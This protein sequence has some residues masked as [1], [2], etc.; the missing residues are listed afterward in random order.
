MTDT[1]RHPTVLAVIGCHCTAFTWAIIAQHTSQWYLP[2]NLRSLVGSES[3]TCSWCLTWNWST[4]YIRTCYLR[5]ELCHVGSPGT[6]L[7]VILLLV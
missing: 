5:I 2:C 4:C 1:A 3:S 7:S 6:D